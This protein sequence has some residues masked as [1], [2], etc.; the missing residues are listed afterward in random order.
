MQI[1]SVASLEL[2]DFVELGI[3]PTKTE[4]IPALKAQAQLV[5]QLIL[6]EE[7]SA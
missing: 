7:P 1:D 2:P 3:A 5:S 4:A 6:L